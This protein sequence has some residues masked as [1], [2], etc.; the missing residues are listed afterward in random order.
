MLSPAIGLPLAVRTTVA[1][2]YTY[3]ITTSGCKPF[4]V[5]GTITV[6]AQKITLTAGSA[7]QTVCINQ[8][9]TDITYKAVDV[10]DNAVTDVT[11]K[12]LPAGI[13]PGTYNTITK[14]IT[15]SGTPSVAGIFK[16]TVITVGNCK[17]DT[18]YGTITVKNQT[19]TLNSGDST[20]QVCVN[21]LI[22]GISYTLGGTATNAIPT[23]L[24]PGVTG[25]ASGTTYTISGSSSAPGT[26]HYT[27]TT[28]GTC[29]PGSYYCND[30]SRFK[31][32]NK[33]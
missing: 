6:N 19:I 27:I 7:V 22:S 28:I 20:Q 30:Y 21:E 3:S 25:N 32:C 23:G 9:I 17:T 1:G 31:C 15:I 26:Y 29:S 18:A 14:T 4:T 13:T 12:G 11:V 24:P 10:N 2:N 16:D 5:T 33:T 8:S